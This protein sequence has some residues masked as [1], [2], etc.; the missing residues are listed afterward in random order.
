MNN[1]TPDRRYRGRRRGQHGVRAGLFPQAI[2][3]NTF[4]AFDVRISRSTLDL[5]ASRHDR[6]HANLIQRENVLAAL[7]PRA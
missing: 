2:S 1:G 6:Q 5:L 7:G 3:L 4:M